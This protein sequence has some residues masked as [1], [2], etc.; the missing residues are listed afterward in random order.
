MNKVNW[1]FEKGITIDDFPR[2]NHF[3]HEQ[4]RER[5]FK[6]TAETFGG[7]NFLELI[8][9]LVY[10]NELVIKVWVNDALVWTKELKWIDDFL[11][12]R[13]G[14]VEPTK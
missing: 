2:E 8:E 12:I 13:V 14:Q 7:L 11:L 9:Y 3:T 4:V 1:E 6:T 5:V 10:R